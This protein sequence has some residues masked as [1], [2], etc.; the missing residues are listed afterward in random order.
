M[1]RFI[2]PIFFGGILL[3][4][5][6]CLMLFQQMQTEDVAK[7]DGDNSDDKE[8][9]VEATPGGSQATTGMAFA[10]KMMWEDLTGS[11]TVRPKVSL[12]DLAPSDPEGWFAADYRTADGEEI[13]QTKFS[14]NPI[15]KTGTNTLLEDFDDAANGVGNAIVRHYMRGS[16]RIAF[17]MYVPDQYNRNTVRGGM[18]AAISSNI[19]FTSDIIG[20]GKTDIFALHHGVPFRQADPYSRSGSSGIKVPVDYRVFTADVGRVFIIKILTNASD[21]AVAEVMKAIP[22][23]DLIARLPEPDPHLLISTTFQTYTDDL[24][25]EAPA[26]TIARKAYLL[27]NT[28]LDYSVKSKRLLGSMV[29]GNFKSWEDVFDHHG[30]ALSYPQEIRDLLGPIPELS[31]LEE[32][33]YTAKGLLEG[34]TVWT[35]TEE[36]ILS[37]MWGVHRTAKERKDMDRYIKDGDVLADEV[38]RLIRLMPET[39]D[40]AAATSVALPE[41]T[42]SASELVIRRGTKIGQGEN[43][44]GNC[45]IELGVRRCVVGGTE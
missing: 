36:R 25:R 8:I 26:P 13:T 6:M 16:Q 24:P 42:V 19:S 10:L 35:D 29:S 9:S 20:G 45:T 33:S 4:A 41:S 17:L 7:A 27:V 23:A 21:A 39:Y 38:I 5:A 32:V 11:A 44:F 34:Q 14:R 40:A 22:M 37:A 30:T 18:M 2:F 43:T 12:K 15:V 3:I 31:P 1:N 28:R